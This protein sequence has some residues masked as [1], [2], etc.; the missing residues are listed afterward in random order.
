[1]M[2][3]ITVTP[4]TKS[5]IIGPLSYFTSSTIPVGAVVTVPVRSKNVFGIVISTKIASDIKSEIRSAPFQI[6]KL[7][8]IKATEFFTSP[9]IESVKILADYYATAHGAVIDNLVSESLLESIGKID[10]ALPKE[11][12]ANSSPDETYAVQGDDGD[13]ISSWRSLIRQEFAK[14]RS[15]VLYVPTL[16]DGHNFMKALEKGIED[17]I[18][19]LHGD[20]TKKKLTEIWQKIS[21]ADHPLFIIS[22][23]SFPVLPRSDI[24]TVIIERENARGWISLRSPYLDARH[25][26]EMIARK[27]GQ[28][29][30]LSDSILRVE[31][32][33]RLEKHE[34]TESSPFKWRSV[35]NARDQLIDM[36]QYKSSENNFRIISPE[37]E[38]IIRTNQ[39]ENTHLFVMAVRRGLSPMTVCGDCETIVTCR[40]CTAPVI[41]HGSK[42]T[43]KN[44][45]M[46]HK[47]GER[48][49]ADETCIICGSWKLVPLGVGVELVEEEIQSK[50]PGANLVRVDSDSTKTPVQIAQAM[51]SF[52][53]K[54]GSILLGTE[55]ALFSLR[56]KVEHVAVISLDS[57]FSLPD[58]RITEKI[59]YTLIRLRTLATRTLTVQTRKPEEKVF[60]YGMKGN[61]SDFLRMTLDDRKQFSYPPY[62]ILIKISIEGDKKKIADEMAAVQSLLRSYELDIFPAFTSTIRGKSMIHGLLKIE[63]E[64]WP[65][66]TLIAKLRELPLNIQV[67]VQPESLL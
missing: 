57:L 56:E 3:I 6:R 66:P 14:K 47:C 19:F 37:L 9:F 30:Y 42:E 1:M 21:E 28:A 52:V 36:R 5:R 11:G 33:Y 8:K 29:V 41:L 39:E 13:R 7:G 59:M 24:D 45:F 22:T 54:P 2:N 51:H 65:D 17:Y 4:L 25:A 27:N 23:S 49:S 43:G 58:F 50:I 32:L 31:T 40:N 34:V 15:I 16:E 10:R 35:S 46:C 64:M 55:M 53:S 20:H 63:R 48:R 18:F 62:S 60:E 61:L 67:R 44:F 26:L 12:S 38:D